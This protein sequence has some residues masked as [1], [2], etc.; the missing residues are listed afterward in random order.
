MKVEDLNYVLGNFE[1]TAMDYMGEV[2]YGWNGFKHD[3]A[4]L[5]PWTVTYSGDIDICGFKRPRSYYRDVLFK[6]GYP[7]YMLLCLIYP[8]HEPWACNRCIP[9]SCTYKAENVTIKVH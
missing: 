2:G 6:T 7:V 9:V 5:Y 4:T 8:S 1:W 3:P